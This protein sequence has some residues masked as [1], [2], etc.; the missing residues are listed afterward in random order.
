MPVY[1]K[2][3]SSNG[4]SG[5]AEV[6]V[7]PTSLRVIFQKDGRAID[8]Y[9]VQKTGWPEDRPSGLYKITLAKTNDAVK[10]VSPPGR[11]EPFLVRFDEFANR[12]GRTDDNPGVPQPKIKPGETKSWPGGGSSY[13]P[14]HPVFSA[15]LVVIEKG[16]YTGLSINY[17]IPYIF[18]NYPGTTSTMFAGTAKQ[19][20]R[21]EKFLRLVGMDLLNEDIPFSDNVLPWL[22]MRLQQL[23]KVFS[24]QLNESGYVA[25]DGFR[26]IPSW[27]LPEGAIDEKYLP[28]PVAIAAASFVPNII[29]N[30]K[31]NGKK[32]AAK[33]PAAKKVNK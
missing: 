29:A 25:K 19:N 32:T 14:E 12:I 28:K 24:V 15:K 17:E 9:D 7:L 23:G 2:V 33:K 21:L 4:I 27:G 22:E 8:T 30:G 16:P 1:S 26:T 10:F 3:K 20:E 11:D 18:E 6:R 13:I 5:L 31:S